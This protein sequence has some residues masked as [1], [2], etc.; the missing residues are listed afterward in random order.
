MFSMCPFPVLQDT[1]TGNIVVQHRTRMGPC[2]VMRQNPH[3]A[4]M[5]LGHANGVVSMWTPNIS[6]P[7][8][9]LFTHYVSPSLLASPALFSFLFVEQRI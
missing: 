2:D 6:V 3:N 5:C 4:V 7:V 8:V 1:S 9:K